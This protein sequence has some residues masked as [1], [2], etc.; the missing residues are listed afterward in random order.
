MTPL[1]KVATRT[2]FANVKIGQEFYWGSYYAENANWGKKRSGR[3]A[4][5]RPMIAGQLSDYVDWGY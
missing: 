4:D 2:T 5:Y 3:T 1:D